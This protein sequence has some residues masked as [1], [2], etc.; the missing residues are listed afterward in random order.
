MH[1]QGHAEGP[2]RNMF[3]SLGPGFG[4]PLRLVMCNLWLLSSLVEK[5][6]S[7]K[8]KTAS[9]VRTTTALTI[10]NAGTMTPMPPMPPK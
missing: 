7:A 9:M 10:F 2:M 8:A 5:I 6:L 4:W 3:E 1:Q